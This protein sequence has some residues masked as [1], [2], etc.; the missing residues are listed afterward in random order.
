MNKKLITRWEYPNVTWCTSS[1]LFIYLRV[2]MDRHWTRTSINM[3]KT[4][5]TQ[6]NIILLWTF[7][8]TDTYSTLMCRLRIFAGLAIYHLLGN[9]IYATVGLVYINLQPKYK[10]PSS[11]LFEQFQKF[12]KISVGGTVLSSHPWRKTCALGLSF[13]FTA[14]CTS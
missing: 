11:I 2:S 8:L 10:L 6:V 7:Q 9:V 13:L 1:Y 12:G 3:H 14:T 4:N 5:H